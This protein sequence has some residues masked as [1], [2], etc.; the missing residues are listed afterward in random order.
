MKEALFDLLGAH[1]S[2]QEFIDYGAGLW[3]RP[4]W[5]MDQAFVP[6]AFSREPDARP[7]WKECFEGKGQREGQL[8]SWELDGHMQSMYREEG[9][10]HHPNEALGT[11]VTCGDV[12]CQ[13][14]RRRHL[15]IFSP[16]DTPQ[17]ELPGRE[18]VEAFLKALALR[19]EMGQ[20][21]E[22]G[23]PS[24]ALLLSLLEGTV[25]PRASLELA[26]VEALQPFEILFA[27]RRDSR[28]TGYTSYLCAKISS[29][30]S[31]SL[32]APYR[33]GLLLLCPEGK[34]EEA[35]KKR[36]EE[37]FCLGISRPFSGLERVPDH[38]RQA[39]FAKER[40]ARRGLESLSYE[41]VAMEDVAAHLGKGLEAEAFCLPG[42]LRARAYD[43]EY[44]TEYLATLRCL[45]QTGGNR[46]ECCERLQIH[47]STLKYRL[48]QL[49][50]LFGLDIQDPRVFGRME[51]SLAILGFPP[52]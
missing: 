42:I 39:L 3:K 4:L 49:K 5:L 12:C 52:S 46:K 23:D 34:G 21:R 20:G 14:G 17:E 16:W 50:N 8:R 38:A 40:A 13:D 45:V 35:L 32:C 25:P 2:V 33:E 7:I 36:L 44:H 47:Q 31:G 51:L 26:G 9:I 1:A 29:R 24:Q 37:S 30:V 18:E 28:S 11:I 41:E 43:Q 15:A 19:L 27:G 10:V 6:E 22:K 48:S